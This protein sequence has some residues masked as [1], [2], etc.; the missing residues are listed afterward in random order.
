MI[1]NL[2]TY[3]CKLQMSGAVFSSKSTRMIL[4]RLFLLIYSGIKTPHPKLIGHIKGFCRGRK[5]DYLKISLV[6][7]N[8]GVDISGHWLHEPNRIAL[9]LNVII[10]GTCRQDLSKIVY[11]TIQEIESL[12]QIKIVQEMSPFY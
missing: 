7:D 3:A 1:G 10:H 4:K 8:G 2:A 9:T 11:E 6:S 12:Y 5:K